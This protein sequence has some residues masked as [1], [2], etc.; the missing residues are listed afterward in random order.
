MNVPA[1]AGTDA[2]H[3][4][5]ADP[6]RLAARFVHPHKQAFVQRAR[7]DD[8]AA[9]IFA[10]QLAGVTPGQLARYHA[11]FAAAVAVS[12]SQIEPGFAAHLPFRPGER[13]LALGDSITDD[14]LSWASHLQSYLDT[15]R[16]HDDIEVVNAGITGNTTQ[17]AIARIDRLSAERPSWVI[18]LL[19]TND[20]RRHGRTQVR[21]QSIQET[22]RN[23]DL[24]ARLVDEE[25]AAQHICLTPPPVA[26]AD[27]DAWEPF[28]EEL[29]TWREE[30][31]AEIADA[32]RSHGGVVVDVHST[33]A[34]DPVDKLLPDGV[35]PTLVG[36]RRILETLLATIAL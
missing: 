10:A 18:Q 25:L 35:H 14:S 16:P 15:H 32:V 19:G 36:Q 17:E 33:L 27:A 11:E 5:V 26:G 30:D 9:S 8:A 7:V 31:V 3:D 29:I 23:L 12:A 2:A 4:E 21:M 6:R 22:R 1:H 28:R 24:L 13:I 34:D 20:A